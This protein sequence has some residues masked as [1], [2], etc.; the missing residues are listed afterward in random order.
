MNSETLQLKTLKDFS[1]EWG[2]GFGIVR[3]DELRVEAIKWIK[4]FNE[5]QK[6]GKE[7]A[8]KENEEFIE[9]FGLD[10]FSVEI[11][12]EYDNYYDYSSTINWIKH[13]FNISEDE[14][15]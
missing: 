15:K 8:R 10:L 9:K 5:A 14:L 2:D 3:K 12:D 1:I 6:L 4:I 13:F 7:P 11:S